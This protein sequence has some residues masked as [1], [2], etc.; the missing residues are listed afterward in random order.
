MPD[1]A[2]TLEP[3]DKRHEPARRSVL[4]PADICCGDQVVACEILNISAG[5]AKVRA[6]AS[7]QYDLPIILQIDQVNALA[8]EVIWLNGEDLGIRFHEQPDK[9]AELVRNGL[10]RLSG[11]QERRKHLRGLVFCSGKI[12]SGYR[13]ADCQIVNISAG[14]AKVRVDQA[15][16][17]DTPITLA[18][19]Q[20]GELQGEVVWQAGNDLSIRFLDTS[21]DVATL[22]ADDATPH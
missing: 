6:K 7:F 18:I 19:D 8:G 9:V 12:Y 16:E 2:H 17:H 22:F 10:E 1:D 20:V 4:W 14:G 3:A 5:G 13:V 15:M 21:S 11:P